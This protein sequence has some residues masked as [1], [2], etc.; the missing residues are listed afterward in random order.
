MLEFEVNVG[1]QS[2]LHQT[3]ATDILVSH[4][5]GVDNLCQFYPKRCYKLAVN[6]E[7]VVRMMAAQ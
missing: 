6:C 4:Y 2:Q 7:Y 3:L 1:N 5:D